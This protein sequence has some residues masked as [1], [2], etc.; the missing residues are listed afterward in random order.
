M[1]PKTPCPIEGLVPWWGGIYPRRGKRL[2]P[3]LIWLYTIHTKAPDQAMIVHYNVCQEEIVRE[4]DLRCQFKVHDTVELGALCPA[5]HTGAQV[6]FLKRRCGLRL[7]RFPSGPEC[8][9]GP[10]RNDPADRRGLVNIAAFSANTTS[11]VQ[12]PTFVHAPALA[13]RLLYPLPSAR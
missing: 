4:I 3:V 8:V 10:D 1:I 7:G 13:Y 2:H 11:A 5:R 6:G 12:M 9:H